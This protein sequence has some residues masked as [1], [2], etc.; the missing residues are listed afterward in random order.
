MR[1]YRYIILA[2]A[3]L[4]TTAL[5]AKVQ[6]VSEFDI[7]EINAIK[8]EI[9]DDYR[10]L[11]EDRLSGD[12]MAVRGDEQDIAE[13]KMRLRDAFQRHNLK[14]REGAWRDRDRVRERLAQGEY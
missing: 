3:L 5:A 9:R 14:Y 8:S 13:D 10:Q 4:P 11:E 6:R 1:K 2:V 12:M 7:P